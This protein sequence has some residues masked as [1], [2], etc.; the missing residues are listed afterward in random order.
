M[1]ALSQIDHAHLRHSQAEMPKIIM[2]TPADWTTPCKGALLLR[3]QSH[4]HRQKLKQL[5][6]KGGVILNCFHGGSLLTSS[7]TS[8]VD[9]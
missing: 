1:N 5:S 8:I 9:Y 4:D 7:T 3:R 6:S 2:P